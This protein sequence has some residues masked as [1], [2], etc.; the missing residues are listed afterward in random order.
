MNDK[1]DEQLSLFGNGSVVDIDHAKEY[2]TPIICVSKD[3]WK[4]I[5]KEADA[6]CDFEEVKDMTYEDA[7]WYVQ[8]MPTW[9]PM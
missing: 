1:D 3:E 7:K 5:C 6:W 8:H 2:E 9:V 4:A